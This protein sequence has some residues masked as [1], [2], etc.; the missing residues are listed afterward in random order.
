MPKPKAISDYQLYPA[1]NV[2]VVAVYFGAVNLGLPLL[3]PPGVALAILLGAAAVT[4]MLLAAA[5]TERRR[6]EATL[7]EQE[8]RY[9]I[10]TELMSDYAFAYR[11]E[12]DG[13]LIDGWNTVDSFKRITG[14]TLEEIGTTL[15]LYHPEDQE[16]VER[17]I[18]AVLEGKSSSGEYR[19]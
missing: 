6:M 15:K 12:P 19:I 7:R 17:D 11:I 5:I 2:I 16:R 18:K 3:R 9:S 13:T 1:Q 14:Y 8:E 10:I 4:A